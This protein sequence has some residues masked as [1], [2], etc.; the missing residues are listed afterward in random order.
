MEGDGPGV[1]EGAGLPPSCKTMHGRDRRHIR[2]IQ[3]TRKISA[4]EF[5]NIKTILPIF[6]VMTM[7]F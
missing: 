7:V 3:A 2:N 4:L 6:K 5:D 1:G